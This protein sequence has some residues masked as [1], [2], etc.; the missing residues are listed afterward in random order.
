MASP[1]RTIPPG[2]VDLRHVGDRAR[3]ARRSRRKGRPWADAVVVAILWGWT[4]TYLNEGNN[5]SWSWPYYHGG[6]P[7][8]PYETLF[9]EGNLHEGPYA[10]AA[11]AYTAMELALAQLPSYLRMIA[12][13]GRV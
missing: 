13:R 8:E 6:K 10:S 2:S 4:P 9:R 1:I 11:E 3:Y 5:T 12:M 7:D